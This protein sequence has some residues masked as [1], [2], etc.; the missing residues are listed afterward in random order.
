MSR[1][2]LL[3]FFVLLVSFNSNSAEANR[4][5]LFGMGAQRAALDLPSAMCV[6]PGQQLRLQADVLDSYGRRYYLPAGHFVWRMTQSTGLWHQWDAAQSWGFGPFDHGRE[7]NSIIV[8][9]PMLVGTRG[10]LEVAAR[11]TWIASVQLVNPAESR[12]PHCLWAHSDVYRGA[13]PVPPRDQPPVDDDERSVVP[14]MDY[15]VVGVRCSD[16]CPDEATCRFV[17]SEENYWEVL[18]CQTK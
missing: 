15:C 17:E 4:S 12:A 14:C 18:N 11:N 3:L 6:F 7:L 10:L 8:T 16:A 9:V 13:E 2:K 5:A 1:F